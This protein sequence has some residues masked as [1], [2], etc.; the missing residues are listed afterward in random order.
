MLKIDDIVEAT[1][2]LQTDDG[3]VFCGQRLVVDQISAGGGFWRPMWFRAFLR[4]DAFKKVGEIR[5]T[6]YGFI[7]TPV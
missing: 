2:D 5:R 6:P 4:A 1:T 3:E 7:A